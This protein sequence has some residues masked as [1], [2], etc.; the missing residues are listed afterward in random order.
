M[1]LISLSV[2]LKNNTCHVVLHNLSLVCKFV[3]DFF[4]HDFSNFENFMYLKEDSFGSGIY[5]KPFVS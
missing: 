4:V 3:D 5:Q 2:F 1:S